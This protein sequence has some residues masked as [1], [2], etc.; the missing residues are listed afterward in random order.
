MKLP[1]WEDKYAPA[2][3][4][5]E[6]AGAILWISDELHILSCQLQIPHCTSDPEQFKVTLIHHSCLWLSIHMRLRHVI[7]TP[8]WDCW[9][10]TVISSQWVT[11]IPSRGKNAY[12]SCRIMQLFLRCLQTSTIHNTKYKIDQIP[13]SSLY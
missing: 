2:H 7:M 5:C 12:E 6:T 3:F 10:P 4:D 9:D 11:Q 1:L 8:G 13:K